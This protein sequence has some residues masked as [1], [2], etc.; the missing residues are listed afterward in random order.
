MSRAWRSAAAAVVVLVLA[1]FV[2]THIPAIGAGHHRPA[3]TALRPASAAAF[4]LPAPAHPAFTPATPVLLA[5]PTAATRSA[6]VLRP[7]EARRR[8]S[9]IAAGITRLDPLTP[10]ATTNVVVVSDV[11]TV[12]G[13]DW[14]KVLLPVLPNGTTGWLPRS[15]LGGYTFVMTRLEIDREALRA[16]LY[17]GRSP[18]F[19]APVGIG[20]AASPTPI[21]RFY[22]REKLTSFRNPFYGPVAFGTNARSATL[23]DWPGGGFIGIHGTNAPGLIPG[24]ISHGCVRLRNPDILRLARLMPVGTPVVIR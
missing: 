8:P 10:D 17:R 6:P 19:Q 5:H 3:T 18:V 13:K 12:A 14:A 22:V 24:R 23:T 15:A 16:T 9:D 7:V 21:G 11:R 20:T 1:A 2:A 4:P